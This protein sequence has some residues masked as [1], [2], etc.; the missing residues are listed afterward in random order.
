MNILKF[1]ILNFSKNTT[2]CLLLIAYCLLATPSVFGQNW[3]L[4]KKNAALDCQF[5]TTD[6]LHN[7]YI[8]TSKNEILKYNEDGSFDA[9]FVNIKMGKL[10]VF[11]ATN[12]FKL[13]VY[14]PDFQ[15]I[16]LLD[17]ELNSL[18]SF[19]LNDL[20]IIRVGA[21]TMS[22]DGNVWVYDAGNNKLLKISGTGSNV[23]QSESAV[24]PFAGSTPTQMLF[25]DNF[26]FV[27][28]PAKGVYQ[29]DR[30]GKFVKTVDIKNI[31]YFQ[32]IDNQ[33]FYK[34]KDVISRFHLQTLKTVVVK[35]PDGV[36]GKEPLRLE[37]NWL[38]TQQGKTIF[39]HEQVQ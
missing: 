13:L 1:F 33:L 12:P 7:I 31:S 19:N 23:K 14:Y 2:Y 10:G 24:V 5:F 28:I 36:T 26:L 35:M 15:T 32:V 27:N 16:Q 17:K 11:D 39:V 20:N 6:N 21:V 25:K 4:Y 38:F 9:R 29:F 3:K 30:F 18:G 8:T 22:D 37:K 34:Q